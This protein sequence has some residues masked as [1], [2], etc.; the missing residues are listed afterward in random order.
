[1]KKLFLISMAVLILG[2]QVWAEDVAAD[3]L[4]EKDPSLGLPKYA[5]A[6][7]LQTPTIEIIA[8]ADLPDFVAQLF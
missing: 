1:M 3:Y 2:A 6:E 4:A 8:D 5:E 7:E